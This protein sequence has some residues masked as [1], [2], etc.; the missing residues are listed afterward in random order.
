MDPTNGGGRSTTCDFCAHETL[1]AEDIPFGRVEGPYAVSASNLFKYGA[2]YQGVILFKHHSPLEFNFLQFS[3]LLNVSN[4][5]FHKA[6]QNV[7]VTNA[8][9]SIE[10]KREYY[11]LFLWNCLPRAG[12]S[13]FH[14]HAQ[15]ML[16]AMPFPTIKRESEASE[17]YHITHGADSDYYADLVEAH[18]AI[19]LAR[20]I[21]SSSA[22]KSINF[23]EKESVFQLSSSSSSAQNDDATTTTAT[24]TAF[25]SLCPTKDAE[26]VVVGAA[27]TCPNFQLLFYSALRALIDEL[28]VQTFNATLYNIPLPHINN[29]SSNN[30]SNNRPIVARV[31]SRGRL[32]S[33]ASDY[34]GMEVFG[35]ATIGH[36][37]PWEVIKALETAFETAVSIR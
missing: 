11:P 10:H 5:W 23:E 34:G 32:S 35:G 26:I 37:D 6:A 14:G 33:A 27:I 20:S 7:V 9:G 2:P 8:D 24:A 1:T 4:G 30:N 18:A 25:A 15:V 29:S 3:D 17:Q 36:T 31:V 22:R 19:G 12:A 16:S 13:Q 28:G 21:L